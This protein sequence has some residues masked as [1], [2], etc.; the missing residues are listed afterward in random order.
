MCWLVGI[1]AVLIAS[2][3]VDFASNRAHGPTWNKRNGCC[4]SSLSHV[5]T[6]CKDC[7]RYPPL[8]VAELRMCVRLEYCVEGGAIPVFPKH[9]LLKRLSRC[10]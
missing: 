5:H 2:D 9:Q 6:H 8:V 10:F 7:P 4:N 1:R 3:L